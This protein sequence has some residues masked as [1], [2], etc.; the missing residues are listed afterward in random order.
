MKK[1]KISKYLIFISFFTLIT[2]FVLML[3][4]GYSN[5]MT[6]AK[7]VTDT[8][9]SINPDLDLTVI[10]QIKSKQNIDPASLPEYETATSNI[11]LIQPTPTLA[12]PTV[13]VSTPSAAQT[14]P[15]PTL[16]P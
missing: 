11:L 14:T 1:T 2:V 15:V 8:S 12:I 4:R 9:K 13:V 7:Q 6:P 3:Q 16:I 5:L 10:E